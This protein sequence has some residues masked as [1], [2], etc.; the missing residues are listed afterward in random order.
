MAKVGNLFSDNPLGRP[1]LVLV[2]FGSLVTF[3][4]LV[5]L[6]LD[7]FC[8]IHLELL[9]DALHV[10]VWCLPSSFSLSIIVVDGGD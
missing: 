2:A 1:L 10:D 8:L 3:G 9:L 7:G 6:D 5:S 4:S